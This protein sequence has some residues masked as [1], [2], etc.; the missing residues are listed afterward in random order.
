M[1]WSK[2]LGYEYFQLH[3]NVLS[4]ERLQKRRKKALE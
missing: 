2:R 3:V 4:L 1:T